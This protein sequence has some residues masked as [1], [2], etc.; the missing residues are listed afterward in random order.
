MRNCQ[1]ER[2]RNVG[3]RPS[4]DHPE[5]LDTVLLATELLL[6]Y[7]IYLI[8]LIVLLELHLDSSILIW[9]EPC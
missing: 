3:S 4:G 9:K 1:T 7:C 2:V 5:G 6:D 8:R